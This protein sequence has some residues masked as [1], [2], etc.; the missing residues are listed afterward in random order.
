VLTGFRNRGDG[1]FERIPIPVPLFA[2]PSCEAGDFT[3]DGV[4]DLV[5]GHNPAG[6]TL[7]RGLGN[8][9]FEDVSPLLPP[10]APDPDVN[11]VTVLLLL[12]LDGDGWLDLYVGLSSEI[13]VS[14]CDSTATDFTC[15]G[16][17]HA[18]TPTRLY[19]NEQGAGFTSI[20]AP[21]DASSLSVNSGAVL[22]WDR[23]GRA[24][25]LTTLDFAH[26]GLYRNVD[27]TGV[28]QDLA[29]TVG[30]DRY[31]HGMGSAHGDFDG[32]GEL[33]LYIADLGP[34][35]FYFARDGVMVDRAA[36]LGIADWTRFHSGW[37]PLAGDFNLDGR[38]DLFVINT[39]I[40]FNQA[41][42]TAVASYQSIT[43]GRQTDYVYRNLGAGFAL[44][45][46]DHIAGAQPEVGAGVAAMADYDADGD[47]DIAE[48]YSPYFWRLL[49]NDTPHAGHWLLVDVGGPLAATVGARISLRAGDLS[50]VRVVGPT[51][52]PG[53]SQRAQHFGLGD[54]RTV[55]EIV[56]T[57]LD[58]TER[59]AGPIA[60]D[61]AIVITP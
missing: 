9:A 2:A 32:D 1:T 20:P 59:T 15:D 29:P 14:S 31:N 46:I 16:A 17:R 12:D 55:D 37:A 28:F 24:D 26:N 58:G 34:D 30:L 60:A 54:H 44:D 49:R 40:V 13:I 3:G 36:E 38:L 35:Q 22:D 5:V 41:D 6:V 52:S 23:D 19:R 51:G 53:K 61:Q 50:L 48:F 4:L 45:F 27:G 43:G 39:A 33:D 18:W 7:L 8:F 21:G 25:L 56:V 11:G 47:L 57:W 42:L 10:L